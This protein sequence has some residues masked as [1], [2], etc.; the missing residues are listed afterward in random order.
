M[1]LWG[2]L[3]QDKSGKGIA[4]HPLE[5]HCADVAAVME[6]ILQ[7]TVLR[8]RLGHLLNQRE[9]SRGQISRLCVFAA[10]HDVGKVNHGFQD[11][12]YSRGARR[13]GHVSPL[14]D[15]MDWDGQE[16]ADIIAALDLERMCNWFDSED[17]CV[18]FL[19]AAFSHHGRPVRPTPHFR[20]E[21]W[22]AN[23]RRNPIE[24]M[25]NLR[26]KVYDWFPDA[27]DIN[28]HVF[29]HSTEFQHAFNGLLTLADWI[30]SD[31]QFFPYADDESDRM[32][33]AR[34]RADEAIARLG[35]VPKRFR[36]K[37]V[38][39][40]PGFETIAPAGYSPH[41]IQQECAE[42][43]DYEDGSLTI[44]ESDTGSGKTEAALTRFIQLLH[45]GLVDGM[46][47][48]LP[49][50]TAATEMH[51]RVR[52]AVSRAFPDPDCRPAVVLAVPGYL[53]VDETTGQ[54][55]APFEVLWND[56]EGARWRYRGWA[57]EHPKRYLAGTIAVGTIDQVLLSTLQVNHAHLRATSLLRHLLIV[58]EVHASDT[59]MGRLLEEAIVYHLKAG[60]HAF[61]MSAT[62]GTVAQARLLNATPSPPPPLEAARKMAYPLISHT[63]VRRNQV[64]RIHP[65]PS[66][67]TKRVIVRTEQIASNPSEVAR[68][69]LSA[70][71]NGARVLIIR[72]TVRDCIAT[73]LAVEHL[74]DTNST[75]LF[76]TNGVVAP[77][78]SRFAGPDR[79]RLD[80]A[81]E[82]L[83]GKGSQRNGLVSVATQT[84]QQ[85]LDLD[86]DLLFSDL[87]P[88]DVLLQRIGR[89]HR[90][91][92]KRPPESRPQGYRTARAVVLV[93]EDRSLGSY[94]R[95]DGRALGPHGLGTVYDDLRILEATW[96]LLEERDAWI[97]PDM[98]RELVEMATHPESLDKIVHSMGG[99]WP[100]HEAY[101][102]GTH[103][104]DRS[105]ANLL[106][107]PREK[108]FG[109]EE[110]PHDLNE[111]I[112]TRL[113]E[114]DREIDLGED[115]TSPFGSVIR[116]LTLP[117]H[118]ALGAGEEVTPE[119]I[120]RVPGRVEFDF[121]GRTFIYDRLGLRPIDPNKQG[122]PQV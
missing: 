103:S 92:K 105:H 94:I 107:L 40:R 56:D 68:L 110:F 75:I 22:Q 102:L 48:A 49:T 99:R 74:A 65:Q 72:N 50:R 43:T 6:A 52:E 58:D 13:T 97:I 47:F 96:R 69:A 24:E 67:Y 115:I 98:N 120:N 95:S 1:M 26:R 60:G 31:E 34:Q 7:Q 76:S 113:G 12:A 89:L 71:T 38:S 51:T 15:F 42:L 8:S 63:D 106:L 30:G 37:L 23:E 82:E 55:L 66:G 104:A 29:P 25:R 41:P 10:L 81:I 11:R 20:P 39:D 108:P 33:F 59:Y 46:Y 101:V 79:K 17:D 121:A 91:P 14:I 77:H 27:L 119:S 18:A 122:G 21:L 70:A 116:K 32:P 19:L 16:K 118:Y 109:E 114:G 3:R 84:V 78:H 28:A 45:A 61:L 62:L 5:A 73:Q 111:R 86:A 87:C 2:K 36:T 57:G 53:R 83:F 44:L 90:H 4:C 88:V 35:L 117:A 80:Q 100:Q 112:K 93:P 9:L 54:R 64:K 85:S